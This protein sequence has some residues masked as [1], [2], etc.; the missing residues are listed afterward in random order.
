M[1]KAFSLLLVLTSLIFSVGCETTVSNPIQADYDAPTV[2]E[3][4]VNPPLVE[5]LPEISEQDANEAESLIFKND[6]LLVEK[7]L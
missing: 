7:P 1:P 4:P 5:S 2:L 3:T 6:R